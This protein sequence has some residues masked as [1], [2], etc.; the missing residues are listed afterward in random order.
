MF[1]RLKGNQRVKDILRRMLQAGRVPGSLLFSGADGIGKKLFAI[2]LA[3]A[4]NCRAPVAREA[5]EVCASCVRAARFSYPAADDTEANKKIIWSEHPD[6]GLLRPAG[7][8]ITVP[9][10]RELEREANF[11]PFEGRTRLFVI[12]EADRLN[13]SSSN[14][15][16]KSLE[17]PPHTTHL[18]LVTARPAALLP[19]IRSRCQVV[20]FAPLSAAEIEAHLL[21]ERGTGPRDASLRARAAQGSIGRALSIDLESYR[22]QRDA[23]MDVLE[24]LVTNPDRARLLRASEELTDAKRKDEYEPRL[25]ALA[26]LIHDSW[27]ISLGADPA[28]VVNG[29]IIERL[30]AVGTKLRS[31]SAT[32]WLAQLEEH[33]R[34]LDVNIN[35]KVATDALLLGMAAESA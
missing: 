6:V 21:G 5:C 12:E 3:K 10:M 20:R 11:R 23:M 32:R 4:L 31:Q 16:L 8:F 14:A 30:K 35:R 17:E 33:R 24:A 29:D 22:R 13:E 27:L 28:Q 2:E 15:L 7:R 1:E 18:V 34:G 26:T 9:Q 25:D 19:T